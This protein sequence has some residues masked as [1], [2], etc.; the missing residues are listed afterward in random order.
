MDSVF[1]YSL[2]KEETA[3]PLPVCDAT[4]RGEGILTKPAV[5]KESGLRH[6]IAAASYYWAGFLRALKEAAFRQ[7]LGFFVVSIA[8]LA[9]VGAT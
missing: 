4:V 3:K 1:A 6:F 2:I 9:L 7:E 8:A 5:T